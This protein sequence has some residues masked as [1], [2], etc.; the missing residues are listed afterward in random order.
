MTD[1]SGHTV[2]V[3]HPGDYGM[4]E[5]GLR[6]ADHLEDLARSAPRRRGEDDGPH[7]A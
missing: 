2:D 1:L 6:L 3:L 4:M 5:I 7:P